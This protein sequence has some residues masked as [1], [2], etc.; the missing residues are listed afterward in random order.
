LQQKERVREAAA[1]IE[2]PKGRKPN[3]TIITCEIGTS[4]IS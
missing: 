3:K 4:S 2:N 1:I